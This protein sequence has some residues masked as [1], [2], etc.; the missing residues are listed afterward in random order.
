M[1]KMDQSKGVLVDALKAYTG[2]SDERIANMLDEVPIQEVCKGTVLLEQGDIPSH[3]YYVIS[4]L[5]RQYV[6]DEEGKAITVDFYTEGQPINMF[7]F[8]DNEGCSRYSLVCLENCV[9]VDCTDVDEDSKAESPEI[10]HMKR[11]MFEKQFSELQQ[12]Y[13]ALKLK[14]PQERYQ[15]LCEE[16]PELLQ[17]VPQ[18]HLASYI[19][20]TPETFSRFKKRMK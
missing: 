7:S 18:I 17:R 19:G 5:I 20:V 9:F 15:L 1:D 10:S 2:L 4:G 6:T 13:T 8:Q 14:T 11:Q 3:S 16:R 12:H